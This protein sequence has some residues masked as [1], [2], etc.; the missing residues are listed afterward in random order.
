MQNEQQKYGANSQ[1]YKDY[2][3][4][5][6][7]DLKQSGVLPEL[8][9]EWAKN[10]SQTLANDSN[11]GGKITSDGI[12]NY[13]NST[14]PGEFGASGVDPANAL[15]ANQLKGMYDKL[16]G[17]NDGLST[18]DLGKDLTTSQQIVQQGDFMKTFLGN[19]NAPTALFDM[20]DTS[21]HGGSPDGWISK[22]DVDAFLGNKSHDEQLKAMGY[23]AD[24]I[25]TLDDGLKNWSDNW[26][27][28]ALKSMQKD[29]KIGRTELANAFGA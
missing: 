1:Q 20:L 4:A 14:N 29:G 17:S 22:G 11:S 18:D 25:K 3:K 13:L 8:T 15:F 12:N 26:N 19:K 10:N 6:G 9:L 24:Q 7:D 23:S 28:D 27:S 2:V 21:Q 5:L 16:G